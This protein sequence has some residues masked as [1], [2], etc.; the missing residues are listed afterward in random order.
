MTRKVY[1]CDKTEWSSGLVGLCL[2]TLESRN[3]STIGAL[4]ISVS[5]V[6]G[7]TDSATVVT[8]TGASCCAKASSGTRRSGADA[9]DAQKV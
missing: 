4:V 8:L 7:E 2:V 5:G 9:G 1:R 6:A 3:H